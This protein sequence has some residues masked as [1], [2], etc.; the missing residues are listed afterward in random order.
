MCLNIVILL[1]SSLLETDE[2]R[3]TSQVALVVKKLLANAEDIKDA[4][5][6][7]GLGRCPGGGHGNPLQY[8]CLEN[9][10]DRGAQWAT[11]HS[12]PKSQ[13]QLKQ[14]SMIRKMIFAKDKN[15]SFQLNT[16]LVF[17][18]VS[19]KNFTNIITTV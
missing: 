17:Y 7:P 1:L 10:M 3:R 11:V 4:C 19:V 5:S 9:P 16:I 12:I 13:T 6:I 15:I 18:N 2:K 8:P 14:L